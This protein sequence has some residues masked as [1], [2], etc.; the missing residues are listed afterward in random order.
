MEHISDVASFIKA[1]ILLTKPGGY[2]ILSVPNN[3]AFVGAQELP[4]NMP[5]H[6]V[7]R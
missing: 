2:I 6:H 7:G 4:L 5:P 1:C 3:D